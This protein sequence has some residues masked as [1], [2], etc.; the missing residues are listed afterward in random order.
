M[1]SGCGENSP[2]APDNCPIKQVYVVTQ[3]LDIIYLT[4][5]PEADEISFHLCVSLTPRLFFPLRHWG[6]RPLPP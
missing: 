4:L 6:K 1:L 2:P 5:Y 3:H